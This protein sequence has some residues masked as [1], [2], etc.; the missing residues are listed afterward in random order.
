MSLF[1][2]FL[3]ISASAK[4]IYNRIISKIYNV[5]EIKALINGKYENIYKD[6]L[7]GKLY[8]NKNSFY[9]K[10]Y[11]NYKGKHREYKVIFNNI[12]LLDVYEKLKE[13]EENHIDYNYLT[14]NNID[15]IIITNYKLKSNDNILDLIQYAN[16]F[17][18]I[19]KPTIKDILLLNNMLIENNSDIHIELEY[20]QNMENK[21]IK[22]DINQDILEKQ[23]ND[24]DILKTNKNDFD[25]DNSLNSLSLDN[26][27]ITDDEFR[28]LLIN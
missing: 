23:I 10:L 22:I 7:L 4:Y 14:F 3:Y 28:N 16:D 9:Q 12:Y 2:F 11:V 1:H 19:T 24:F 15:D 13:L 27:F 18:D 25:I 17:L 21:K 20:I 5:I 26:E 8:S 6:Y